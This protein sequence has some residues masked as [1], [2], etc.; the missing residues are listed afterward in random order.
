MIDRL[1]NLLTF[2]RTERLG[3]WLLLILVLA[4]NLS[5]YIY[6][7]YFYISETQSEISEELKKQLEVLNEIEESS[8]YHPSEERNYASSKKEISLFNFDPNLLNEEEWGSLGLKKYQIKIISNYLN[9]GGKFRIKKDL[10]KIH[11]IDSS[12]FS[13]VKPY[14]L[15]PDTI[16]KEWK[17]VIYDNEKKRTFTLVDIN[18]ADSFELEK[19]PGLGEYMASK[20]V[21]YREKLGGFYSKNQLLEVWGMNPTN[22]EM[23]EDKIDLKTKI[24]YIDI[25]TA[26]TEELARHPYIK[27]KLANMI[28][29]YIKQHGKITKL[30]DLKVLPL[31]A[32]STIIK[33]KP[34]IV[35]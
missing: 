2:S 3:I 7:K 26:T 29:Q 16:Q 15:L 9:K 19:L 32:D 24:K 6:K 22:F 30:E 25:N 10:S 31:M 11:S 12:W 14:I 20:I 23:F 28:A 33:M 17:K 34:Y 27:K 13:I 8:T 4:I 5:P 18:G 21:K 35:F 1:K